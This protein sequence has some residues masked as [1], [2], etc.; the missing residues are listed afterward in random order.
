MA[1][2]CCCAT[3]FA[4]IRC[5]YAIKTEASSFQCATQII[6]FHPVANERKISC[7]CDVFRLTHPLHYAKVSAVR[8][9]GSSRA[10]NETTKQQ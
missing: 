4:G 2:A 10:N 1:A 9:N 6:D 7:F 5:N 3:D 8:R